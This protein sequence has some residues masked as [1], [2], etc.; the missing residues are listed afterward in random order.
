MAN[1]SATNFQ[2]GQF[3]NR[4]TLCMKMISLR[5]L[6]ARC[7][8][9]RPKK[10]AGFLHDTLCCSVFPGCLLIFIMH[11]WSVQRV[12]FR[13]NSIWSVNLTIIYHI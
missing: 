3:Y 4:P 2:M 5:R 6:T 13:C 12:Y 10:N 8:V 9:L 1:P 7:V 11:I